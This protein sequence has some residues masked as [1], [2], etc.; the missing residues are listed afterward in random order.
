MSSILKQN[1]HTSMAKTFYSDILSQR[2]MY[3]YF[4]GKTITWGVNDIPPSIGDTYAEEVTARNNMIHTKR[5]N[6]NDVCYVI[7]RIDWKVDTVYDRYDGDVSESNPSTSGATNIRDAK[8]YVVTDQYS[9]YKC[10]H[11]NYGT[12]STVKPSG[13]D[14]EVFETADGYLWKYMYT[15]PPSLQYRFMT[16]SFIPVTTAL[17]QRYFNNVS[18]DS[19]TI[20][21]GGSGYEG[22][23]ITTAIVNG[24]GAGATIGLNIDPTNGKITKARIKTAGSGYTTG[25]ISIIDVGGKGVGIY[26]NPTAVLTPK[27]VGG[28]LVDVIVEDPGKDYSTDTQTNIII[29]GTG[30]GAVLLPV[31]ENGEIVDVIINNAGN[32]YNE[33]T[34]VVESVTGTGA[35]LTVSTGIGN[36]DTTQADVELLAIPGAVYVV[37]PVDTGTGYSW[38]RPIIS[39]DGSGLEITPTIYN[40]KIVAYTVDAIGSGYSWCSI[41]FE[42]DGTGATCKPLLSPYQGHGHNAIDELFVSRVSVFSTIKFDSAQQLLANNDYRQFGIVRNPTDFST[43]GI[44]R[45]V[46]GSTCY[47][48]NTDTT[49]GILPDDQ[50]TLETDA[51]KIIIVVAVGQSGKML[52]QDVSGGNVVAGARLKRTSDNVLINIIQ[53]TPPEVN[54]KSGEL[55]FID[56]RYSIFQTSDQFISLRTTLKF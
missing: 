46:N 56:N 20:N 15:I 55:L 50:L 22:D 5:I 16:P 47:Y 4:L 27:F 26:G 44:Y 30:T 3:Y 41:T 12:E 1:I 40:G 42:G 38:C 18:I 21:S 49:T 2:N 29:N 35:Q 9:V 43:G 51:T 11:N 33:A 7:P 53:V 14:Y 52:L 45:E 6:I 34:L 10:I 39:G 25:T 54:K 31:V 32:S 37:D 48:V 24:N 23:P 17:T 8:F 13:T 36:V 19:V 28:K